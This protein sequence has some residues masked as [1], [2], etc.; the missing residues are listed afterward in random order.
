MTLTLNIVQG[1][2]YVLMRNVDLSNIRVKISKTGKTSYLWKESVNAEMNFVY[3]DKVG[4]LILLGVNPDN[5]EELFIKYNGKS[6]IILSKYLKESKIGKIF[7][8]D[9]NWKFNI[10]DT[11]IDEKRNLLI[12]NRKI[13]KNPTR[14]NKFYQYNCK[15]CGFSCESVDYWVN[16]ADIGR[17]ESGCVCCSGHL[18]VS[19]INDIATTD[20]WM[21]EYFADKSIAKR[22]TVGSNKPQ[23]CI[24]PICGTKKRIPPYRIK[25]QGFGCD[26]CSDGV[27]YGEKFIRNL[28]SESDINFI[29]QLST[30][31]FEWCNKYKYDFYLPDYNWI[32]EVNG[33]QHYEEYGTS[34]FSQKDVKYNDSLKE[35]LAINYVDKYIVIDCRESNF[36][37]ILNSIKQSAL[38]NII[39][40]DNIDLNKIEINA[41]KNL[42]KEVCDYYKNTYPN[43]TTEKMAELFHISRSGITR[44]LKLGNKF[45]LCVYLGTKTGSK[46]RGNQYSMPLLIIE[47]DKKYL[48]RSKKLFKEKHKDIWGYGISNKT[49]NKYINSKLEYNN[50]IIKQITKTEFNLYIDN[51]NDD[52]CVYGEPFILSI[53]DYFEE[54]SA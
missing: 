44:Y 52:V 6:H 20:S 8:K 2:E 49:I 34:C 45:G 5:H 1:G 35:A 33:I 4:K 39:N 40:W 12:T 43:T 47:G 25:S 15:K 37:Y 24:C 22:F 41:H 9:I 26:N 19:G 36:E 32:I 3:D 54:V 27:S 14:R 30:K 11:I 29:Y 42:I 31:N 50:K 51:K 53:L 23:D 16:E 38:Y 7:E 10:G 18:A 46:E 13:N 48:F 28:L 17:R 21:V